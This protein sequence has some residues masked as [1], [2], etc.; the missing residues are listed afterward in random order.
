MK[1]ALLTTDNREPFRQYDKEI[2]WFGSAPEALLQGFVDLPGAEVHVV[3]CTQRPMQ[4]PARLA[5]NIFFHSL[6]V[7]KI[8][9]LRTGYQGCIRAIHRKLRDIKPDIVHGQGTERECSLSAILSGYPNVLTI[10]GNM[11]SIAQVTQARPFSFY[12]LAARLEGFT[13]PRTQGI[14]CITAYTRELVR[15]EAKRTWVVPNAVDRSFFELSP[16]PAT[17]PRILCV[18]SVDRRKNQ[19][20]LI[21]ALD[22]LRQ[23]ETFEVF[24]LG[25]VHRESP[26]GREF[27]DLLETR[28]WCHYEGFTDRASLKQHLCAASALILPS[29]EDNCPMVVLEAMAA[30]IPVAAARVGGVPELIRHGDTGLLFDPLDETAITA[31]AAELLGS[32]AKSRALRA[33]ADALQRFHPTIIARQHLDIY[34]DVLTPR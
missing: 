25:Q 9:W 28:P 4:S 21:R 24:F 7:P 19:N 14:V 13:L 3:T 15:A 31:A 1:I 11:R 33:H 22:V 8:G 32:E 6:H 12:W 2:P 27:L 16:V 10:H 18:G 23:R 34:R 29:L 30:G 26:F 5:Q 20:A 17:P